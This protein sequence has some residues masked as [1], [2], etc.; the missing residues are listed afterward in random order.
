MQEELRQAELL[1]INENRNSHSKLIE[2][3]LKCELNQRYETKRKLQRENNLGVA[4]RDEKT[5]RITPRD[6]PLHP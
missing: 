1:S 6:C 4:P 5:L 2:T 3:V